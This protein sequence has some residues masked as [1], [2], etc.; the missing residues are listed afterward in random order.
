MADELRSPLSEALQDK[1][2]SEIGRLI[3]E[4]A[5][6]RKQLAKERDRNTVLIEV[7]QNAVGAL[8][9][10]EPFPRMKSPKNEEPHTAM[11][12]VSDVH[13][14]AKVDPVITG[15]LSD[16]NYDIFLKRGLELQK[17]IVRLVDM[18]RKIYPVN[19][20]YVNFLGDMTEG[21]D[22]YR[23]QAF[24]I[25]R[26]LTEQVLLG[27]DWFAN[28]L[29][30]MAARFDKIH[31]RAIPGNHGRGYQK[32]QSHPRTNW[33]TVVYK[34]IERRLGAH[35]NVD[36]QIAESAWMLYHLTDSTEYRHVIIHGDEARSW[37]TIPWY[38][39]ERAGQRLESMLGVVLDYVHA[40][41][42]HNEARWA[43]NRMEFLVNG[44]WVG[45]SDLS[46][47]KL[48]RFSRPTQNLF[49]CHPKR[50]VVSHYPIQLDT[51]PKLSSDERGIWGYR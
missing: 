34:M 27:A 16:Y 44:S 11:I 39:F 12:D 42:H 17:A 35:K 32:G 20:L 21:E 8:P 50:G 5:A 7:I 26:P 38:G 41:H 51:L 37:M 4:L 40:G 18:Q 30:D 10:L 13:V 3:D 49:F 46:V 47:R 25:D 45:G 28:F 22:I 6:V 29:I 1:E 14:G 33:D 2:P 24:Q 43:N 9:P 31:V 36:F 15:G 23:G 48:L 19:A